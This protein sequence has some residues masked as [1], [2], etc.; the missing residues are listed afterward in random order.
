MALI[1]RILRF[2]SWLPQLLRG[3]SIF[4]G[5]PSAR[6]WEWFAGSAHGFSKLLFE[7]AAQN[8]SCDPKLLHKA[9][10]QSH[11]PKLLSRAIPHSC[12]PKLLKFPLKL[13]PKP[14]SQSCL[15]KLLPKAIVLQSNFSSMLLQSCKV[16]PH[17]CS[18]KLLSKITIE[19]R[20]PKK[21]PK[22]PCTG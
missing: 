6:F 2:F 1:N 14:A 9:V 8:C 21:L 13:I 20:V 11:S 12:S 5:M 10:P 17:N 7:A 16:A 18:R 19:S 4:S 15:L 3:Y 22:T